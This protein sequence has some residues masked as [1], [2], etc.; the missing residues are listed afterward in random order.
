MHMWEAF[1]TT[2]TPL[3]STAYMTAWYTEIDKGKI[4]KTSKREKRMGREREREE[5]EREKEI[6]KDRERD[7]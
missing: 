1:T 6:E 4:S 5:R 7:K 3:G 2:R